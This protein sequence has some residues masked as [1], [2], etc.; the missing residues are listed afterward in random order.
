MND[1]E[2]IVL[3]AEDDDGH[4]TLIQRHLRRA[5]LE[6][7]F[8]RARNGSE[9]LDLIDRRDRE[10]RGRFVVLLDIRMPKLDGI[11]LLRILKSE[12]NTSVVPIYI[13]T[14]TDD[15]R[16]IERCFELGCNAFLTKPTA[17]DQLIE[18]IRRLAHFLQ[19]AALPEVPLV[20]I[21]G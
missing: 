18:T 3:H 14:T 13:F 21:Q 15:P 12:R 17:P 7:Q 4:A 10:R 16:D 5:G 20:P 19:V 9:A 6:A 11:E 8:V 1:S 2:M